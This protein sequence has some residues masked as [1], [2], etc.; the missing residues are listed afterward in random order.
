[1][2]ADNDAEASGRDPASSVSAP[3]TA[4]Q[5]DLAT[6]P[7]EFDTPVAVQALDALPAVSQVF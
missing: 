5:Q 6:Q 7:P 3:E 4:L 1:M 2:Q